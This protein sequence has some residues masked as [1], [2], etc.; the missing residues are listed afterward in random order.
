MLEDKID[1]ML[2]HTQAF[3]GVCSCSGVKEGCS[4]EGDRKSAAWACEGGW[5]M[6]AENITKIG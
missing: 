3:H 6:T 5:F 2:S 4:D 1:I